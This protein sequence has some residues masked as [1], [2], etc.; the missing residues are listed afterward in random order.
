M[1]A[2]GHRLPVLI[3]LGLG[4]ESLGTALMSPELQE[5][6]SGSSTI[7]RV[8]IKWG[9]N[10]PS[11][12]KMVFTYR[13]GVFEYK[14]F[15]ENGRELEVDEALEKVVRSAPSHMAKC[16]KDVLVEIIRVPYSYHRKQARGPEHLLTIIVT[17]VFLL[18]L[19][20]FFVDIEF[21]PA[22]QPSCRH[23]VCG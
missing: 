6:L 14:F 5:F 23:R 4:D 1:A 22:W 12:V 13:E 9:Q 11:E 19:G 17:V 10:S 18:L 15:L 20:G 21:V 8:E 2:E 7:E 16:W 3:P